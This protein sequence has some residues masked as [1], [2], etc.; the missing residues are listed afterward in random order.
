MDAVTARSVRSCG[1]ALVLAVSTGCA[2]APPT[3]VRIVVDGHTDTVPAQVVCT[4]VGD[5]KLVIYASPSSFDSTKRIR[6]LLDTD[7]RLVVKT[8]GFHLPEANGFTADSDEMV[9]TK[10]DDTYTI[11]GRIPPADGR[12]EW[13]QLE[14]VVTCP[15]YTEQQPSDRQPGLGAP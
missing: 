6:V 8:V 13:R 7:Y 14:I 5:D 12:I 15:G 4:K 9:A 3:D 11:S 2:S 1:A 10:V